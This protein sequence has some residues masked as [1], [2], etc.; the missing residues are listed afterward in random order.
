MTHTAPPLVRVNFESCL[1][2]IR[3]ASIEILSLLNVRAAEGKDPRWFLE[4]LEVARLNLG[5]WAA[6]ARRLNLNDAEMTQ[7]TIQLR[8][9]HQ[10]MQEYDSGKGVSTNQMIAT[11]R[12][13]SSLEQLKEKQPLLHYNTTPD[14]DAEA[15][16]REAQC[17]IRAL[18]LMIKALINR[19]WPDQTRL[20]HHLNALF[21]SEKVRN[22][23]KMADGGDVLSGMLFSDLAL[24]L[25]DKK[26]Y[27]RHYASIFQNS[28]S[29]GLLN[30]PR[31]T[32]QAFLDDIRKLR[33][34]VI[35]G[36]PLTMAQ[37]ALLEG[38][39]G[40]ITGPVQRAFNKGRINI[41]PSA[42]LSVDDKELAAFY[43]RA[44][45]KNE[46]SGGDDYDVRAGIDR[47]KKSSTRT[48]EERQ[49]LMYNTLQG[50][51]WG[52]VVLAAVAIVI[53]GLFI[54]HDLTTPRVEATTPLKDRRMSEASNDNSSRNILASMGIDWNESSM[55]SAIN[56]DDSEVT[57][58]FLQGGMDWQVSWTERVLGDDSNMVPQ[59]LLN[60]R[61]QM[62]ENKPCRRMMDTIGHAMAQGEK[63]N[64]NRKQYL[65]AFCT[66][67][68]A[69][70]HQ[71]IELELAQQ[72]ERSGGGE[73]EKKWADIQEAI[74]EVIESGRSQ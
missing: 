74:Y 39:F 36:Q 48:P 24:L 57:R 20:L 35:N 14:N 11:L 2:V 70:G 32:L 21:G 29:L 43:A 12:L 61:P 53:G 13:I 17:Q 65:R 42:L 19:A 71:K 72:R 5:S 47:P 58:L 23:N 44:G 7:F 8:H 30:D 1:G 27:A 28:S 6:V 49:L 64:A 16:P 10:H 68:D 9:V 66:N 73:A 51:L 18:E 4:Q 38:Y 41:N 40:E 46:A 59:L 25:V 63:L 55:R 50:M 3:Q 33:N 67:P 45:E 54:F 62:N 26:E 34:A 52:T 69:V 60:Y 37:S 15:T 22:W 31:K 56:R